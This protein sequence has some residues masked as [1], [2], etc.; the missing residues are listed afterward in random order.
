MASKAEIQRW[1]T[2]V[3]A[4]PDGNPGA[5]THEATVAWFANRDYL[6]RDPKP[7]TIDAAM[8][9]EARA[10]VVAIALG[11]LGPGG[12]A[13]EQDPQKYIRDAAP[14]YIGQPPN[15]KA[16]CG[17][18]WL[19]CLRQAGLTSKQWVDGRGF[20]SGYL[21]TVSI[22]EPGDGMY[23]GTPLHHYAVV[24]R[25]ASGRVYTVEGNV[26]PAP[27]E[28][29]MAKDHPIGAVVAGGGGYFSIRNLVAGAP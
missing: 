22:P 23:F 12:M 18:F 26:L 17:I 7:A 8:I 10:R 11:E 14:I 6:A 2:L 1:Q 25:V 4:T 15:A 3:G 19:W 9:P 20:A 28:G 13:K 24:R 21:P 5:R 27:R 29:L 16:W